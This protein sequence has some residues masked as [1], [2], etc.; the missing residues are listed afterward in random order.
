[1]KV[2]LDT[3]SIIYLSDFSKFDEIITVQDVVDEA[4]DKKTAIKISGL[5]L[6]IVEPSEKSIE[7]IKLIAKQTGDLEKLSQTDIQVLATALENESMI[8]S[9]DRN[10]Q[11]V[12]EKIGIEYASLFNEKI[13]KLITWRKFCSNCKKYF[14]GKVCPVCGTELRRVPKKS[15]SVK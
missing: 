7:K 4:K 8:I 6:K 13:T 5:K 10:I 12:A 9:D 3:S 14:E 1:M 11:N 2:V 15:I